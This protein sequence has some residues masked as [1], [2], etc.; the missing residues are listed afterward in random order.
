[1]QAVLEAMGANPGKKHIT[2]R[3]LFKEIIGSQYA[4]TI[5]VDTKYRKE[6]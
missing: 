2:Y 6:E 5:P 3:K 1:M 4:S